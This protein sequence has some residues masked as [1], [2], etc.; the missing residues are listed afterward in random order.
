M[1]Q[2]KAPMGVNKLFSLMKT[3]S[4]KQT[5]IMS[6][7]RITVPENTCCKRSTTMKSN[8]LTL[9]KAVVIKMSK[10]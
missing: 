10:A 1:A 2:D 3:M 6:D 8:R 7:L 4:K 5:W 9:C